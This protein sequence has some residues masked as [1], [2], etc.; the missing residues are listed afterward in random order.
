VT[1]PEPEKWVDP[2]NVR[3]LLD[4]LPEPTKVPCPECPWLRVS[5][6]GWLG[7]YTADEWLTLAHSDSPI[8]CHT[9]ITETNE[10]GEGDW[11][12]PQMRQCQGAAIFRANVFKSPRHPSIA[13]AERDTE[14]VFT[15]N[16]EFRAHHNREGS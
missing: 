13:R 6:P 4:R 12:H 3:S 9:T 15:W 8:A 7:P 14:M 1:R 10:E 16:D 2:D 5:A 11:S